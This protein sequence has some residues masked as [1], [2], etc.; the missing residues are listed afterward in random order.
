MPAAKV[1]LREQPQV[2][3]RRVSPLL[4]PDEQGEE[5]DRAGDA[6]DHRGEASGHSDPA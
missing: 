6:Q 4:L 2:D 1:E 3:Q 5:Y